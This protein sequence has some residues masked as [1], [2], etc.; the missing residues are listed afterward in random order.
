MTSEYNETNN[1]EYLQLISDMYIKEITPLVKEIQKLR[2]EHSEMSVRHD[3]TGKFM[4][5]RHNILHQYVASID[6]MD[7]FVRKQEKVLAFEI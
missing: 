3:G 2:Y 1:T 4:N 6:S 7:S 5:E